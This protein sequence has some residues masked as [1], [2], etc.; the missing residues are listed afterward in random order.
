MIFQTLCLGPKKGTRIG[1]SKGAP[2]GYR[3]SFKRGP[4]REPED[5]KREAAMRLKY[6]KREA[7][8][9]VNASKKAEVDLDIYLR[10]RQNVHS[11]PADSP[12]AT[13]WN[14]GVT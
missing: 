11:C 3:M 6:R 4:K 8:A 10:V 7:R 13:F 14:F 2:K 9:V 5:M 12:E 1:D